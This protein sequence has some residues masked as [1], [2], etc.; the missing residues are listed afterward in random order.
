MKMK[1]LILIAATLISV[2]IAFSQTEKQI[3]FIRNE[4]AVINKS[5]KNYAKSTKNVEGISLEGTEATY[6]GSGKGLKKITAKIYGET[7]NATTE[8]YYSGEELIFIYR[9]FN[10]YDTQIGMKPPPKV[11]SIKESRF[12]FT[13]GKLIKFLEGKKNIKST[14]KYWVDS[15]SEVLE[16]AEKL[17]AEY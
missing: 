1:L 16:M 3:T 9:K 7:Y 11:V 5:I 12:Y 17:K 4:V 13:N 10:R 14:A 15:E 2:Q 8:L 6:Y